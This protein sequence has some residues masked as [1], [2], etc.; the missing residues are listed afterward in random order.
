MYKRGLT[1]LAAL[2]IAL[3]G[4]IMV[5]PASAEEGWPTCCNSDVHGNG[6]CSSC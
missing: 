3:F 1:I 6:F 4:A 5:T 2:N